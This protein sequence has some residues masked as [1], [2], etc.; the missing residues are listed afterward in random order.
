MAENNLSASSTLHETEYGQRRPSYK[1]KEPIEPIKI[2][3]YIIN[4]PCKIICSF[5]FLFLL[6]SFA[7][8]TVFTTTESGGREWLVSSSKDTQRLDALL[9][10]KNDITN[11]VKYTADPKTQENPWFNI[12]TLFKTKDGSNILKPEYLSFIKE[13]NDKIINANYNEYFKLCL[14]DSSSF[15]N[16]SN[17]AVVDPLIAGITENGYNV[18]TITDAQ[19]SSVINSSISNYGQQFYI[20][21]EESFST[22]TDR[23]SRYY[24]AFYKFGGPY[25]DINDTHSSYKS[26]QD[27]YLKQ[28]E[29]YDS[30]IFPIW[31]DIQ[32]KNNNHQIIEVIVSGQR[33][34]DLAF[35]MINNEGVLW[36]VASIVVVWIIMFYH[37][38]SLFLSFIAITQIILG[39][40]FSYFIYRIVCGITYFGTLH[41]LVIFI[42]LGIAADDCFVFCD[43]WV[44]SQ[45]VVKNKH[46]L[47]ERMSY[48]YKRAAH[49]MAVTTFTTVIAFLATA[50]SPIM[51]ISAFGIWAALVIFVNYLFM[52]TYFPCCLS[53]YHQYIRKYEKCPCSRF[54]RSRKKLNNAEENNKPPIELQEIAHSNDKNHV[55]ID[56]KSDV[57]DVIID[58]DHQETGRCMERFFRDKWSH[59]MMACKYYILCFF[60]ILIVISIWQTTKLEGLSE[61]EQFF[62]NDHYMEKQIWWMEDFFG[63]NVNSL[64]QVNLGWGIN[65]IPDRKGSDPWSV[66]TQDLGTVKYND[67]FDL[68]P[69]NAQ[70]HIAN[71]CD[72]L[73]TQHT[74]RLY[75]PQSRLQC[76][77]YDLIDYAN[78]TYNMSFP[79]SFSNDATIQK[80]KFNQF[81]SNWTENTA[82]GKY[83][84][85]NGNVGWKGN[86]EELK[87]VVISYTLSMFRWA[88]YDEKKSEYDFWEQKIAEWNNNAPLS[89]SDAFQASFGFAWMS[90]EKAFMTSAIQGVAMALPAAFI[91]LLLSTRNWIISIFATITI[92]SIILTEVMV[93]VLQGWKLGIS[94][95]IAVVIMIGFSV[96]YVV[97]FA[98]AYIECSYSEERDSRI[99][100]SLFTM[101]ISII[102]GAITTFGSGF[103]LI[104]PEMK[105][106]TKFGILIMSVV[107]LS[108]IYAITFFI[109][110]LAVFGPIGNKGNLPFKRIWRK[111]PQRNQDS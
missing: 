72:E 79:V 75:S 25:P 65:E 88:P 98:S 62:D 8:S 31:K 49:A 102:F 37:M 17:I 35:M 1:L 95:S 45:Y 78:T 71:V 85:N 99:R 54:C 59:W 20:N 19:L 40:P 93:M 38:R 64:V 109:A 24:R 36:S 26:I 13:T 10:S 15:P 110:L 16:C 42:I 68:S 23:E 11:S 29:F 34:R 67:D 33:V 48:S 82:Q 22:S 53:W 43:S 96:D 84:I 41:L 111:K 61:Q 50:F 106:Y 5:V 81:I 77:I 100:Y 4:H 39:F 14:A 60:T 86:E 2:A 108:L 104:F 47:I 30:W 18:D 69:I 27:N 63:G 89:V 101:G 83:Y 57:K 3:H 70:Q 76:F 66:E 94:E 9:L 73:L 12:A 103:F 28:Q 107:A 105:F 80:R 91:V 7:I 56:R 55:E 97:H 90:S 46:D 52:I 58:N 44:Q 74:D 21:F 6:I 87:F 32:I 92:I 51:P